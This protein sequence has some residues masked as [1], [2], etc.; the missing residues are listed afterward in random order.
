MNPNEYLF[1]LDKHMKTLVKQ[2]SINSCRKPESIYVAF[3]RICKLVDKL[4]PDIVANLETHKGVVFIRPYNPEIKDPVDV[5][6]CENESIINEVIETAK[7]RLERL[8]KIDRTMNHSDRVWLR[9]EHYLHDEPF[10]GGEF[11]ARI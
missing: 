10:K 1:D 6:Q 9:M 11:I 2:Q 5:I 4:T 7:R 3:V 8:K